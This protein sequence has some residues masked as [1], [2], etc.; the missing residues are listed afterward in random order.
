[1]VAV[2][3]FSALITDLQGVGVEAGAAAGLAGDLDVGQEARLHLLDPL[4]LDTSQRPPRVLKE[5]WPGPQPRMRASELAA[6]RLRM[7]YQRPT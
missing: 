6:N 7:G 1:M 2:L 3:L 4:A 5:K